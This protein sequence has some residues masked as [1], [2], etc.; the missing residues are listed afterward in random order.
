M[1]YSKFEYRLKLGQV[2][3]IFTSR[4][5]SDDS[6]GM[7]TASALSVNL[8]PEREKTS[9]VAVHGDSNQIAQ[10]KHQLS[11]D[12]SQQKKSLMTLKSFTDGGWEVTDARIIVIVKS[13][14][15]RRKGTIFFHC[16]VS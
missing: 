5:S 14:G 7:L 9:H 13:I 1:C 8:F 2:V 12:Y 10:S 6:G 16:L 3:T 4:V 15:A 11:I